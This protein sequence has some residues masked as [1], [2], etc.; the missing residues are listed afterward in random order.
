MQPIIIAPS[1]LAADFGNLQKEIELIN[2]SAA[3][4]LHIDV[5]DGVFVPNI[6]FGTPI[7]AAIAKHSTKILDVHL[8]IIQPE[9]YIQTFANL[10]AHH[11]TVHYETCNNLPKTL[12]LIKSLGIKAGVAINPDTAVS[13][14]ENFIQEIDIVIIMSVHPGFGGQAFIETT[15]LKIALLKELIAKQN[16]STLIQIDGGVTL[17]NAKKIIAAGANVLVAG[18]SVFNTASPIQT[19]LEFKKV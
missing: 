10:G 12:Q 15:Y 11:V 9:K 17:I 13:V 14:L 18:S 19:I 1:I 8:M 2:S 4:W 7:M 6:S 16:A 5:M 3:E